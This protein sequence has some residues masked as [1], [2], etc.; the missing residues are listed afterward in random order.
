MSLRCIPKHAQMP[1]RG[2]GGDENGHLTP[3][4][5]I[6]SARLRLFSRDA[7]HF[8]EQFQDVTRTKGWWSLS[9]IARTPAALLDNR[10]YY[11]QYGAALAKAMATDPS[12]FS[13]SQ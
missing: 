13:Q 3:Q 4:A 2:S 1:L 12:A 8:H 10:R 11:R 7:L 6:T 9:G 5:H